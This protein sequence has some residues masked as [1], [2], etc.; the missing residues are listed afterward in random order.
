[1]GFIVVKM[2]PARGRVAHWFLNGLPWQTVIDAIVAFGLR[3]SLI[4][5]VGLLKNYLW[6]HFV[7]F[8]YSGAKQNFTCD[9]HFK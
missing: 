2:F 3:M 5:H 1:M 6:F 7:L 8:R 4:N 9:I